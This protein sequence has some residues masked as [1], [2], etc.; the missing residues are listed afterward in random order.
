MIMNVIHELAKTKTVLL[1]SHR[2]ANVVES[3]MIYFLKDGRIA[4]SGK[5]AQLMG[6]DGEYRSLFERQLALEN[7]GKEEN[8]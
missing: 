1:I 3:D 6:N 8:A 2:L 7:Y 4:E 5:H